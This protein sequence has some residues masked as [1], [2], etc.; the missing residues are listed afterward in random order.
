MIVVGVGA[1]V[2]AIAAF[3]LGLRPYRESV[4]RLKQWEKENV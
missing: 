1:H 4:E 3:A 2:A